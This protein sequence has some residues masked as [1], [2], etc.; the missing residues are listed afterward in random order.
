MDLILDDRPQHDFNRWYHDILIKSGMF[1][2]KYERMPEHNQMLELDSTVYGSGGRKHR[3]GQI[4]FAKLNNKLVIFDTQFDDKYTLKYLKN[5]LLNNMSA[6]VYIKYKKNEEI[7]SLLNCPLVIWSMFPAGW[8]LVNKF[9]YSSH[10][11]NY[12]IMASGFNSLRVMKRMDWFEHAKLIGIDT[13]VAITGTQYLELLMKS[14]FGIILSIRNEK[15][16]REYEFISNSMPLALNYKPEFEFDFFP[17]EHYLYMKDIND[18]S[19]VLTENV[20]KYCAKSKYIWENYFRP[21]MASKIL[22]N[23]TTN[24][25]LSSYKRLMNS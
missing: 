25:V 15:N 24:A 8:G 7:Q 13:R 17:N 3:H 20:D 9:E 6:V 23:K 11:S 10:Q 5:G 18:L 14:R 21:D 22:I 19:K 1:T 2:V 16:T 12:N 4:S